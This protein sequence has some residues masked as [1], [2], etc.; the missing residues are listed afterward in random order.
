[1]QLLQDISLGYHHILYRHGSWLVH[2]SVSGEKEIPRLCDAI[3]YV[4]KSS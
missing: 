3:L 1:M 4:A 2:A